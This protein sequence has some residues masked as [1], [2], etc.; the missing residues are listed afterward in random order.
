[1]PASPRAVPA[2]RT[3]DAVNVLA[4]DLGA[5]AL[6]DDD[7]IVVSTDMQVGAYTIAEGA[8]VDGLAR[9]VTVTQTA[10][11]AEDTNG[12]IVVSGT[13]VDGDEI[14]ETI[15]PNAGATVA[16]VKAFLEVTDVD[17]AGWVTAGGADTIEVGFGTLVGLPS[18][19]LVGNG[20]Y[21][22]TAQIFAA[23]LGGVVVAANATF[24]ADEPEKN[25]VDGSAGTYDGTKRLTALL[26]R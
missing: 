17:G 3:L 14:T 9:N 7:R 4:I 2:G 12:T 18:R 26:R 13:N 5:P 25:T 15:V 21:A 6:A 10:T 8:S 19:I 1:M 24:D 16:G 23:F 20:R 11:D 22:A